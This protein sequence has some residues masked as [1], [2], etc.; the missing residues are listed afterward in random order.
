MSGRYSGG[1]TLLEVVVA[2]TI[3]SIAF[4]TLLEMISF[5]RKKYEES[6]ETFRTMLILDGKLKEGNHEGIEVKRERV[7]D[8]PAIEEVTY[9]Y[10]GLFFVRYEKR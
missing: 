6:R 3:I 5:A 10:G 9:S 2:L 4:T 7:P 8:F 1:F